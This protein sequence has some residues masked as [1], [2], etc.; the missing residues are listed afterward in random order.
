MHHARNDA[1]LDR[2]FGGVLI[3]FDRLFGTFAEERA[4]TPCS[5]GLVEPLTTNNPVRIAFHGW[6]RMWR[7]FCDA[8]GLREH[9][10]ALFGPPEWQSDLHRSQSA[11]RPAP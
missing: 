10:L 5:Y 9:A 1:Y 4:D 6:R 8:E 11:R 3:V 7:E 2:N